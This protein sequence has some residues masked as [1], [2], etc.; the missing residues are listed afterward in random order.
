[1]YDESGSQ[2]KTHNGIDTIIRRAL[3]GD[4]LKNTYAIIVTCASRLFWIC[5][6]VGKRSD[7]VTCAGLCSK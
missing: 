1:M 5:A 4:A 6:T 3:E 2:S 7:A